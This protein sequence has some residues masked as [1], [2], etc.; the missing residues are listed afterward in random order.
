MRKLASFVVIAL[1]FAMSAAS[2]RV[3]TKPSAEPSA[4]PAQNAKVTIKNFEFV[5]KDLTVAPGTT[6][7]WVNE[8]GRHTVE[9]DKGEFKSDVLANG[10]KFSF[11]FDKPGTYAYHCGFHGAAGGKDM[12]GKIIVKK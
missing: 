8:G 11:K 1:M 10:G 5:P 3:N 9:A 2:A 12:A 7:E 4:A 6:V